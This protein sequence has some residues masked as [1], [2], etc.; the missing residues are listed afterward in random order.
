MATTGVVFPVDLYDAGAESRDGT[1]AAGARSATVPGT[2]FRGCPGARSSG[3]S[4]ALALIGNPQIAILDELTT[5]LDT[6]G[7]ARHL[8]SSSSASGSG[9]RSHHHLRH[10]LHGRGR[11]A[12]RPAVQVES[13][14]LDD[15]YVRL[16]HHDREEAVRP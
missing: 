10:A 13:A 15:A 11:T 16:I 3:C 12:A 5:G 1:R 9:S 7:Q 2:Y 14:T 6:T 8:G 4:I